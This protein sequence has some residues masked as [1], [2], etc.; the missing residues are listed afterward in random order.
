MNPTPTSTPAPSLTSPLPAAARPPVSWE[1]PGQVGQ[2]GRPGG[3]PV[4]SVTELRRAW[5]AVQAGTYRDPS[6]PTL[7]PDGRLPA[8]QADPSEV[9]RAPWQRAAG[10]VVLPV[11][12][13]TGACGATVLAAAL[14]TAALAHDASGT[15]ATAAR[16]VECS[17]PTSSG[18]AAASTSEL[19]V[20][21]SGWLRGSRGDLLLERPAAD[22]AGAD[23]VPSPSDLGDSPS[24][25]RSG[26]G[27]EAGLTVL[28]VGWDL[29]QALA[30]TSWLRSELV[31][32]QHLVLTTTATVPGLRR[33]EV[34]LG[35]LA[36]L[37]ATVHAAVLGPPRRRWPR[38]VAHSLGARTRALD[39]AGRLT[40]LPYDRGLAV[41]GLG[42]APLPPPLLLA[43]TRLLD[44]TVT[45]T[46]GDLP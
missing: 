27:C 6:V 45:T 38:A 19:G 46:R 20:H 41:T 32:A 8:W 28:D 12:G 16:V 13:C 7:R 14:A 9:A 31:H 18:L 2:A 5:A 15:P 4:V 17:P 22:V 26:H 42:P 23:T 11:I 1:G 21:R 3:R 34:H 36:G 37:G 40:G 24:G 33:L 30:R 43:A 39:A 25:D 29:Q 35:L 10:E 44:A